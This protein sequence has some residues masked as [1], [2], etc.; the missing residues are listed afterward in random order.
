MKVEN[1]TIWEDEYLSCTN[2]YEVWECA[3]VQQGVVEIKL[4]LAKPKFER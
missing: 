2:N 3:M 1:G 4:E